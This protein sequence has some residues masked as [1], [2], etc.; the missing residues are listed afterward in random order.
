[1]AIIV[2]FPKNDEHEKRINELND[3]L[4]QNPGEFLQCEDGIECYFA[5]KQGFVC[6]FE[7]DGCVYY[8]PETD[9]ED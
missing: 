1:M 5:K 8:T 4:K 7:T 3:E 6:N 2:K 9:W